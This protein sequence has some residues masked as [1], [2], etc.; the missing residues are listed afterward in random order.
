MVKI[1]S[2]TDAL[3]SKW[4]TRHANGSIFEICVHWRNAEGGLKDKHMGNFIL[5]M[6]LH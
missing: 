2:A 4:P 5:A 1:K 3:D 6:G